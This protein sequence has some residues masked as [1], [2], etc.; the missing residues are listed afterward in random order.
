MA[1]VRCGGLSRVVIAYSSRP[2]TIEYLKAAFARR[3]VEARAVFADENTW[4]DRLVIHRVNKL[5]HNFRLMPKSRNLFENHPLSHMNFRSARLRSAIRAYDPDLVFVIRG[6][7]YRPWAADGAR[8]KFGWWVEADERVAEAMQEVAR[9]DRYFFINSA[10][11][12]VAKRAGYGHTSY[13]PHAVD[14]SVFRPLPDV[15]KD[16]DF[17]F[18]GSWSQKRQ[19]HLE[20]ALD[21]SRN[22]AVYGKKWWRK[23]FNDARLWRIVKGRYIGGEALVRLY[24]RSKIVINVTEWGAGAGARRSGMTMRLFEVPATGSFL[25]TDFS[26]DMGLSVTPGVHVETFS[27]LSDFQKKL[28]FYLDNPDARERIATQGMAHVRAHCTYDAMVEKLCAAYDLTMTSMG[29]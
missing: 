14:P 13:L 25:L 29:S 28:R 27:D 21:V 3:G 8:K 10:S 4:F 18:V 26:V 11:V 22:G 12:E 2:P 1:Q 19:K 6:L 23:T 24:N 15:R 5:A 17:C 20:A 7:G 9:Y 16:I